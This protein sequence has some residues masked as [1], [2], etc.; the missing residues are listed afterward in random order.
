MAHQP[1]CCHQRVPLG[2]ALAQL[3]PLLWRY[4]LGIYHSWRSSF[5]WNW[6]L[7]SKWLSLLDSSCR[8]LSR[9]CLGSRS[10]CNLAFSFASRGHSSQC[11]RSF[12]CR[13][14]WHGSLEQL[15]NHC[16]H[17]RRAESRGRHQFWSVANPCQLKY[18]PH[19]SWTHSFIHSDTFQS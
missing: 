7:E 6:R 12:G 18:A 8:W 2:F 1:P 5:S 11:R 10:V 19:F 15:R 16:K 9:S 3:F 13:N 14:C 4:L 17:F